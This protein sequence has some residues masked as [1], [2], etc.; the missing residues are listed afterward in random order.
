MAYKVF[1]N[2]FPLN[3]SELNNYLMNQSVMVFASTTAR[4]ADLTAPTEGMIVWLQD[5]NKFVYY[6][7]TAWADVIVSPSTGNAIING[8]FD[9]WQRGTSINTTG[10]FY[11]AD[12][13]L[14]FSFSG[15]STTIS[16][17]TFT[18]GTAPVSGYEGK[19]FM[20][21]SST[22]T[23]TRFYQRV[24]DVQTFAGQTVTVSFWAKAASA[25]TQYVDVI[26]NFGSGG[27]AE[28]SAGIGSASLTTSW[29]RFSFTYAVPS[30]TGKTVGTSSYLALQFD[31]AVNNAVDIWGVQLEAGSSATSFARAA[32]TLQG[33]LAACQR[34]YVRYS[35][36][37][38]QTI[39]GRGN[40][41]STTQANIWFT[42]PVTMRVSPTAID[43]STLAVWGEDTAP[44]VTTAA[45]DINN[46]QTTAVLMTVASGLTQ[47][48]NY[49]CVAF[50]SGAGYIGFSAEL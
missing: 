26:Q 38:Y 17:Q 3:A 31:S 4:D 40:A 19:Y 42:H 15:S 14:T 34:Y 25:V 44:A 37:A 11:G 48:R 12:R 45:I 49:G 24:E 5:A 21:V 35:G 50:S 41:K 9:I 22:N 7:G 27:S 36:A 47:Y 28:T 43:Y 1:Q 39:G 29:Q 16:R 30:I 46:P 6:T 23:T 8:A 18:P 20:R 2:G 32:A 10:T 13:W 33:E